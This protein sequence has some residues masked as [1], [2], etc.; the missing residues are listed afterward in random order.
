[1]QR[2]GSETSLQPDLLRPETW[3]SVASPMSPPA[4]CAATPNAISLPASASGLTRS[5]LPD[6]PMIALSGPEAAPANLSPRQAQ[7]LGLMTSGTFGPL[8]II[9]SEADVLQSSLASKLR[10]RTDIFGSTLFKLTWKVQRTPAGR[11]FSL[12]RALAHR[13]VAT[14]SSTWPTPRAEDSESSGARLS[15]G[16]NDTLTAVTRLAS[17]PT[18]RAAEA[19]PDYAIKD[20]PDSGGLS[21]QTTAAL[22]SWATPCAMEPDQPPET[23]R[24]RKA[25]LSESTGVHRGPAFPL[26][27]QAHLAAWPTPM[28]GTP[29]QKGYN[30]AGNNDSSRKT[31]ELAQWPTPQVDSFRSR[32]GDR[33]GEMGLDQLARTIPM[34]PCLASGSVPIGFTAETNGGG[35]L[36]PAHSRWLMGLPSTWDL[37]A[38]LKEKAVKKC[39]AGTATRSSRKSRPS[40]S[41]RT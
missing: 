36:S 39:S 26:G 33:K 40:S 20:R 28:A 23:V 41:A 6:G 10:A 5:D 37:A 4:I 11:S 16:V 24:D 1:M 19:G 18:P 21:L 8:G 12:L 2:N 13:T 31:V 17:W 34:P 22:S 9:S 32:S 25:R 27:S 3:T 15:R 35:Q 14:E 7:A 30:E 29:A 38:P